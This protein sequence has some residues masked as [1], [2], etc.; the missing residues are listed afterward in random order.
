M[1]T[2]QIVPAPTLVFDAEEYAEHI[3]L[4][5][6]VVCSFSR[7]ASFTEAVEQLSATI[8]YTVVADIY[9][10]HNTIYL[11]DEEGFMTTHLIDDTK[12]L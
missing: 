1:N 3:R 6:K 2:A 5:N 12:E 8:K 11:F 10:S 7:V 4:I 9:C